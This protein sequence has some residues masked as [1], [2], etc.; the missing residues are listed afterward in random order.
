MAQAVGAHGTVAIAVDPGRGLVL[1]HSCQS[2]AIC[3][4]GSPV[5]CQTPIR[6]GRILCKYPTILSAT[7]VLAK[8]MT[9]SAL[10]AAELSASDVVLAITPGNPAGLLRLAGLVH[11]GPLL[12]AANPKDPSVK[13]AL[14]HLTSTG[15][16]DAVLSTHSVRAAVRAVSRGGCVCVPDRVA[17]PTTVTEFVQRELRLVGPRELDR[18][19]RKVGQSSIEAALAAA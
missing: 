1:D 16:A 19:V 7:E 8:L 2:C 10:V 4:A 6:I 12:S 15:R 11:Q 17:D 5:W 3:A 9:L 18:T 13:M 14:A